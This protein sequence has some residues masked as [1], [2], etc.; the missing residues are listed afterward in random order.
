MQTAKESAMK[1]ALME[2]NS[3]FD[4]QQYL[5]E[6]DI[7]ILPVGSVEQHG[8]HLPLAT[9]SINVLYLAR[10]AAEATQVLV[11]P[12]IKTGVSFNHIDF[13]GTISVHPETLTTLIID[14]VKS[15]VRHGFKKII[16]LNGHGGNNSAIETAAIKLKID[17]TKEIIGVLHSWLLCKEAASV[18]E[19]PIRYHADEGETSRML[20]SATDLVNMDRAKL[21]VPTSQSGLFNFQITEVFKQT[22]FYGLPRTQTVTKSGIFGDAAIATA[23]KG[24]ALFKEMIENFVQEIDRLKAVKL[25]DYVEG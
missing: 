15:L 24:Q 9:D 19:S 7:I 23:E 13:P 12:I 1:S 8:P 10:N 14:V 5:K 22:V 2:E 17:F 18:L 3:W 6:N 11:A 20:V 21:E 25:E 16:L 4:I